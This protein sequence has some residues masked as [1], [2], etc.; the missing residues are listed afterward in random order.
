MARVLMPCLKTGD[1]VP[2][3]AQR[4]VAPSDASTKVQKRPAATEQQRLAV[5]QQQVAPR[6]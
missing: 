4:A 5:A 2:V 6:R 1:C 3:V